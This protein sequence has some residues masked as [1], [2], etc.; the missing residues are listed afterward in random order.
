MIASKA[1]PNKIRE[2]KIA[3]VKREITAGHLLQRRSTQAQGALPQ[4]PDRTQSVLIL[5]SRYLFASRRQSCHDFAKGAQQRGA[6]YQDVL[7]ARYGKVKNLADFV[8]KGQLMNYEAY[9]AMYEGREAA[10]FAP[11]TAVI[12]WMSNPAQPSF[13]WQLYHYD[14]EANASLYAVKKACEQVHVMLNEATGELLVVNELAKPVDGAVAKVTI[15]DMDGD[16]KYQPVLARLSCRMIF[17]LSI[18]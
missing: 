6:A 17:P 5:P 13:V 9:R 1:S 11:T 4:P 18:L 15:Y 3:A 7:A 16:V 2:V 10:L 8:R 12:T 14:L